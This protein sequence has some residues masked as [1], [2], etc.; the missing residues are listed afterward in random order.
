MPLV[1]DANG[2]WKDLPATGAGGLDLNAN[3]AQ[4]SAILDHFSP[5]VGGETILKAINSFVFANPTGDSSHPLFKAIQNAAESNI[6]E[7]YASDGTT[8]LF[9]LR[10]DGTF[11]SDQLYTRVLF[12]DNAR[13]F[14]DISLPFA[15]PIVWDLSSSDWAT[16]TLTTNSTLVFSN[17]RAGHFMLRIIMGGS[18]SNLL[19]WPSE[20]HWP[21]GIPPIPT[22][23]IGALDIVTFFSPDAINFYPV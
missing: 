3:F 20:I 1:Q 9:M 6:A 15:V 22:P 4:L 19:T 2:V 7:F 16:I 21:D 13:K 18:G 12:I 17:L 23:D 5:N 8:L 10:S 14:L 11:I